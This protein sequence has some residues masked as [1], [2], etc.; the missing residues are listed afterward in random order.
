MVA[1]SVISCSPKTNG[2]ANASCTRCATTCAPSAAATPGSASA[3]SS[4]PVRATQ[5]LMSLGVVDAGEVVDGEH[6]HGE[7][8]L[9]G[10]R[11]RDLL[12]QYLQQALAVGQRGERIVVGQVAD[13]R[14]ALAQ[15][16]LG[17]LCPDQELDALSEQHRVDA[18][19]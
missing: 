18:L 9:P 3:N 1:D 6:Q 2:R 15:L 4:P 16:V 13:P 8:A 7:A 12:L 11:P 5:S 14:F 17:L 10:R 19:G